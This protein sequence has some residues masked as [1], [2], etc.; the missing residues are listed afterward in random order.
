M[1]T[2]NFIEDPYDGLRRI[3]PYTVLVHVKTY[4]GGAYGTSWL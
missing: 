2:G 1:D 4:Y 3:A